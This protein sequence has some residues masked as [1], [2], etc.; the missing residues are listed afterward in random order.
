M[1]LP[2]LLPATYLLEWL[3]A[4]MNF[5][6]SGFSQPSELAWRKSKNSP[7][8]DFSFFSEA[9]AHGGGEQMSLVLCP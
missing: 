8:T 4:E 7:R 3:E 2:N 9:S 1:C 5:S 6:I